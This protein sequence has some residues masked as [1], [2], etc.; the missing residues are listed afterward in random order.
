YRKHGHAAV[1]S[2]ARFYIVKIFHP[3]VTIHFGA[4]C[5]VPSHALIL[6]K[7]VARRVLR[8]YPGPLLADVGLFGLEF[9]A[10]T[11]NT[12]RLNV[13]TS[14]IAMHRKLGVSLG[15][16]VETSHV[17]RLSNHMSGGVLSSA[18]HHRLR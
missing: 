8:A 2:S 11:C 14:P 17:K 15:K 4:P 12:A 16:V 6:C 9:R 5:C 10:K 18:N 3:S 13:M 1:L 7:S